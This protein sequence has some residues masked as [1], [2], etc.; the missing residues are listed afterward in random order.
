[1]AVK[2]QWQ[3]WTTKSSNIKNEDILEENNLVVTRRSLRLDSKKSFMSG[4]R[5]LMIIYSILS[6]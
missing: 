2:K 5:T 1:L 6:N 4:I 3:G